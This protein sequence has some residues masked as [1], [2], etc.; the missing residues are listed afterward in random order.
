MN[1][2]SASTIIRDVVV[3]IASAGAAL[4]VGALTVLLFFKGEI[5]GG[6]STLVLTGM[7]SL[8]VINDVKRLLLK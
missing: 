1:N 7:L 3:P 6:I 2:M 4:V 5:G 8:F